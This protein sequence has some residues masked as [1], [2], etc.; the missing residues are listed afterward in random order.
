MGVRKRSDKYYEKFER[1]WNDCES[2]AEAAC[3][4]GI[5]VRIARSIAQQMRNHGWILKS[6]YGNAEVV[7]NRP[8]KPTPHPTM[9][10]P[11]S[12]MKIEVMRMRASRDEQIWHPNDATAET[13]IDR[14]PHLK[15]N[16]RGG[17]DRGG[18]V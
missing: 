18:I 4:L 14:V 5:D 7:D 11:G 1:V 17:N 8:R 6:F 12:P 16:S 10:A 15:T 2:S 9:F 13:A 3:K